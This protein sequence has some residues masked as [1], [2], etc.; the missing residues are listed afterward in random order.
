MP[1]R[2]KLTE[3]R[4][5]EEA[6]GLIDEDGI[7]GL[8]MRKLGQRLGTTSMSIYTYFTDK[9]AVL[10]GVAQ[11][12]LSEVDAP[13]D[14]GLDWREVVRRIMWSYREVCHRH[15]NA[16][17]LAIKYPPTTPDA[18]AFVEAGFRAL[19]RAGFDDQSI[20]RSY[21]ALAA[22]SFGTLAIEMN[23]YYATASAAAAPGARRETLHA[24]TLDKHLPTVAEI[25]P[26]LAEQHDAEEFEYGL[27]LILTGFADITA[28][29]G[30]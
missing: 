12:I 21:R 25:R 6:L 19:R 29:G 27:E 7:D 13:S 10:A 2:E 3:R 11:L 23:G 28:A 4:I 15:I 20:A 5:A 30:S 16:A 17:P 14:E 8:S 18:L 1:E 9:E 26:S 22:Y 24:A